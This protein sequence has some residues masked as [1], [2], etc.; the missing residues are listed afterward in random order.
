MEKVNIL[1]QGPIFGNEFANNHVTG[2]TLWEIRLKKYGFTIVG[3][4]EINITE[5][6][7]ADKVRRKKYITEQE[8]M[9]NYI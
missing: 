7:I 6:E 5:E 3:V 9:E 2:C 1:V 4:K 8:L